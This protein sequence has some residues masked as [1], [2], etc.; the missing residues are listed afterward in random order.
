MKTSTMLV[1]A[2]LDDYHF[3]LEQFAAVGTTSVLE[4][5]FRKSRMRDRAQPKHTVYVCKHWHTG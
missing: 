1:R 4:E 2:E 3:I 5:Y